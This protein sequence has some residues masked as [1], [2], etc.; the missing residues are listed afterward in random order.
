MDVLAREE[1][2]HFGEDVF[3]EAEGRLARAV[4]VLEDAEGG[5]GL[6]RAGRAAEV[7]VGGE[8]RERVPRHFDFG[9]DRDETLG[10]VA[11]DVA[12]LVLR[13]EAAVALTVE[14]RGF[15][16]GVADHGLSTE[17]ADLGELGILLDLDAPPL[18]FGQVPVEPA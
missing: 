8:R 15:V 3:E 17:A 12:N 6:E 14:A 1:I 11:D 18:V 7:R 5:G 13:V 2:D 10:G 16:P 9:N 4:D